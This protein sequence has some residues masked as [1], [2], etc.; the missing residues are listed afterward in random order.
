M[1]LEATSHPSVMEVSPERGRLRLSET[2]HGLWSCL[3]TRL[4]FRTGVWEVFRERGGGEDGKPTKQ[5]LV[6]L[7]ALVAVV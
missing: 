6:A 1:L 2:S 7:P 3:R 5:P 4:G